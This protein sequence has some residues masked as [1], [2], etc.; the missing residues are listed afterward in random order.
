MTRTTT[1]R[2]VTVT[3][4]VTLWPLKILIPPAQHHKQTLQINLNQ[5]QIYL[6]VQWWMAT[7]ALRLQTLHTLDLKCQQQQGEVFQW[8]HIQCHHLNHFILQQ[9]QLSIWVIWKVEWTVSILILSLIAIG[10]IDT[11]SQSGDLSVG[12]VIRKIREVQL[13]ML[14]ISLCLISDL[15]TAII[16]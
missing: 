3:T 10:L 1:Q 9:C 6:L 12:M 4:T 5:C 15:I 2:I 11:L 16:L 7:L 13:I 8:G 14:P